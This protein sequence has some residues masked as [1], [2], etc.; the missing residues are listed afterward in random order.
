MLLLGVVILFFNKLKNLP[1]VVLLKDFFKEDKKQKNKYKRSSYLFTVPKYKESRNFN[2]AFQ[3]H[4]TMNTHEHFMKAA[5]NLAQ[6][7][8]D[9]NC[10]GPFGAVVVKDN[11]IIAEG[12][13]SVTSTN[14]PTAHAEVVA[15]REACKSLNTFQLDGCVI[16][17]SCEPCPMC[18]GAIYWAR[19]DKVYFGA[20]KED[21]AE[22]NFDD[23]FIYDEIELNFNK[24]H[25][26][27]ENLMRKDANAVFEAWLNKEDKT[28]Y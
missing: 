5:I 7:G 17:T 6:N 2:I 10:G 11:K 24:R 9:C 16:Y 8:M 28:A 25:I 21:A 27:F 19:P 15:I 13:N 22:V 12:S 1:I 14:D 3:K 26:P 23:H 18:L 20:T 4:K